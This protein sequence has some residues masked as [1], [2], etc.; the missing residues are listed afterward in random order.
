[1]LNLESFSQT[2]KLIMMI[3]GTLLTA[4]YIWFIIDSTREFLKQ[5]IFNN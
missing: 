1:M 3:G 5:Y 4:P 2:Q